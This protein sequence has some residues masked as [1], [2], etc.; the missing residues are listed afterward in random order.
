VEK[1]NHLVGTAEVGK[2]SGDKGAAVELTW[3]VKIPMRD[4]VTL[5]A[6]VYRPQGSAPTP[7]IF[8]LTPYISDSYHERAYYFAGHGYAFAL[9]DCRGRGNSGGDFEP[10]AGVGLDGH[11]VVEWLAEQPWCDGSVTMWGGS[12]AGF[13]QWLTLRE[14][15]PHLGTIVPAAAAHP[16]VDFPAA[17]NVFFSYEMRWLTLVS[18]LTPNDNLFAESAY[19]IARFRHLYLNHLPYSS[20]DQ[21]VGNRNSHFQSWI[22]HPA[23]DHFWESMTLAAA[24]YDRIDMPILTITGHYDGDQPGAM[25]YYRRHMDSA[26]PSRDRHFLIIGPWDHAGT[27]TPCAEF[28]GLKFGE[29]CLVNLN[30]LHVAWY[31]WTLRGGKKPE[32]LK[33]RV[34]YYVMGAEEWKYADDLSGISD[35]TRRLYLDSFEGQANDAFRSGILQESPPGKSQPDRYVYDPLDVRPAEL[36]TEEVKNHLTDQRYALNLFGGGLIYHSEPLADDTEISGYVRLVAW[37]ALDVPDTDFWVT[38]YEILASGESI[39]LAEDVLR[40]RYRNSLSQE[41]LL[42]PGSIDRYEFRGFN[43]FSRRV[44]RNSRLRLVLRAPNSIYFQKNYNSGGEVTEESAADAR[45]AHVTLYHDEAHP[46][47]LELPIASE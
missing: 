37:L 19:W 5:N 17:N 3:G 36:E 22:K 15:P 31:D 30:E 33:K 25:A 39:Q 4:G 6:T 35:T 8:T 26:S 16:G 46:S 41:E 1:A 18:G 40:A 27:R 42:E 21:V 2:Q 43:F 47:Y 10:M 7:A 32:F 38:L 23:V 28:G 13:D 14:R 29:A 11:D 45:T 24:D 44:A 12:Y 9:V 34:A 20:L